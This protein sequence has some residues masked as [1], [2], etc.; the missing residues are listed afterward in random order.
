MKKFFLVERNKIFKNKPTKI[1]ICN[2]TSMLLKLKT[3]F[4]RKSMKKN[5][6]R[7]EFFTNIN[8]LKD[9]VTHTHKSQL[10]T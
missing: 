3:K 2:N 5:A 7:F 4:F 9:K 1:L 10:S 6:F 8:S